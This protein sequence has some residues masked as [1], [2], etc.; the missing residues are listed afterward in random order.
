MTCPAIWQV[1]VARPAGLDDD[2]YERALFL[3]RKSAERALAAEDIVD[4]YFPS[5]S[6]RTIVYK[7]LFVAP[8]LRDFY[9]D[10]RDPDYETSLAVFHQRY[11]TN[12][13]PNWFMAQPFRRLAHN[14]EINTVQGNR[15]WMRARHA[16]LASPIWGD[17][18]GELLPVIVPGGSDSAEDRKS[19]RL[20]SI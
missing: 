20:N 7:G 9:A 14:G 10:L 15:N 17:A 1:I 12:T 13:L 18:V 3:A 11:S 4:C 2:A 5:F 16:D 19:T 6:H 8:Q